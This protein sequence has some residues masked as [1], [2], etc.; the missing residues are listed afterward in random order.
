MLGDLCLGLKSQFSS[1]LNDVMPI[2]MQNLSVSGCTYSQCFVVC[3]VY[4]L[5][6]HRWGGCGGGG[7]VA[8]W[9]MCDVHTACTYIGGEGVVVEEWS[10][11]GWCVMYTL[12]VHRWGGCGGGG[13]V[14]LWL[15]C[16]VCTACT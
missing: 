16:D 5:P 7:V 14:A 3:D 8:L 2:L 12:P 1:L 6:V 13:V 9:L 10:P 4:A 11:C 15:V